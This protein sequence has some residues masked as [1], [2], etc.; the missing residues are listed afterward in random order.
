MRRW[1]ILKRGCHVQPSKQM[2]VI[3]DISDLDDGCLEA[4]MTDMNL[5]ISH[6]NDLLSVSVTA[7]TQSTIR[8]VP[9]SQHIGGIKRSKSDGKASFIL[10]N[11][12]CVPGVP[13]NLFDTDG[14]VTSTELRHN[15][16]MK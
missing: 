1:S 8:Q 10:L 4:S 13:G 5:K 6:V 9:T 16:H 3:C 14:T 2:I 11:A 12:Q 15:H 7:L